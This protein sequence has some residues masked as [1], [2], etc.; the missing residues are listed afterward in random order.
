MAGTYFISGSITG[1]FTNE[2]SLAASHKSTGGHKG[3][4]SYTNIPIS[5]KGFYSNS[6]KIG[7]ELGLVVRR[8]VIVPNKL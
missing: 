1:S 6:D 7:K 2:Q 3:I 8:P 5:G 4:N